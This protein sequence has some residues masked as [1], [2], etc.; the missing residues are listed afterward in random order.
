M[1][2]KHLNEQK[3]LAKISVW[4]YLFVGGFLIFFNILILTILDPSISSISSFPLLRAV[5]LIEI[6]DFLERVDPLVILLIYVGLFVK[7]TAFYLGAALG[8]SS[9]WKNSRHGVVTLLTGG[10]STCSRLLR[11]VIF[12]TSGSLS[13]I[14]C[15]FIFL[16]FKS[17]FRCCLRRRS[18]RRGY[19]RK[20]AFL[21][22]KKRL[23][24]LERGLLCT[25][26]DSGCFSQPPRCF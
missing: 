11:R 4:S 22:A 8:L 15:D 6:A 16:S 23:R 2:M 13:N 18:R 24:M 17:G 14:I 10:S 3:R 12:S 19:F 20:K 21:H 9:L 7:M 5:R 25:A 1:F 26:N